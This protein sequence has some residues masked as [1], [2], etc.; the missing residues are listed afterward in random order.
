MRLP[1][2]GL[3]LSLSLPIAPSTA[4]LPSRLPW[5]DTSQYQN[6]SLY[7]QVSEERDLWR[8]ICSA[9]PKEIDPGACVV[10]FLVLYKKNT[11][12]EI[13]DIDGILLTLTLR[14]QP[15]KFI[16]VTNLGYLIPHSIFFIYAI[17]RG[18]FAIREVLQEL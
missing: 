4:S 5:F 13:Y 15:L 9:C 8:G 10:C 16:M 12:F 18:C 6:G 1:G 7:L 17:L 14:Y 2:S 11:I 3:S